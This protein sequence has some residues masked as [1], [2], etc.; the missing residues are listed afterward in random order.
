MP[1]QKSLE[2]TS[3]V[4][5][6]QEEFYGS[7]K[8]Y[9]SLYFFWLGFIIYALSFVIKS[10]EHFNLKVG[11]LLQFVG[12]CILLPSVINIIRFRIRNRYLL[13]VFVIYIFWLLSNIARGIHFNYSYLKDS[14]LNS[15]EGILIYF[16]PLILLVP[17]DGTFFKK[18]FD[19]IIILGIFYLIYDVIFIQSLLDRSFETQNVVENLVR[20][21]SM[22]C[23]FILLTYQYHSNRRKLFAFIVMIISLL[24]SI[25]KARRGLSSTLA[26]ILICAYFLYLFSTK[27][28]VLI[29]YLSILCICLGILYSTSIYSI[30]DNKLFSF[31]AKRGAV[32][33]RS[34]VEDFF[35]GDMKK[36]D[37][38][39][40]KGING[41]YYC[42]D[43]DVN[44]VT[45]YR[46][47]IE[48]GYLQIILK[49]GLI[50][51]I[52][53]L[54]ISVPAVVLGL[55]FSRNI[56]SKAAAIWIA[57]A[58]I[59]LYPATVESFSLQY[60]LVWISIS[61]C[62]TRRLRRLNDYDVLEFLQSY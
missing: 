16:A 62:Y 59:S 40:G 54:L 1:G 7:Q 19:F 23:G 20:N 56:L 32:D 55:F 15:D 58:I 42:P 5:P 52:L 46:D 36:K 37:W 33:T 29:L 27:N 26:G 47:Y 57:V 34:D 24:F 31:I 44:Q 39:I 60:L 17:Q 13:F 61:I 45:D 9:Y 3:I 22:P 18:L 49:G 6:L 50:R 8:K 53:Y 38:I 12:F 51:L 48:T 4:S 21:L 30:N 2:V 10:S 41:E 25:Y 11:E 35:Y 43:I 28:K 14:L